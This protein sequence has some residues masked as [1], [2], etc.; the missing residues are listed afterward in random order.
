MDAPRTTPMPTPGR[1]QAAT[2]PAPAHPGAPPEERP[3]PEIDPQ[4]A[5]PEVPMQPPI[6]VPTPQPQPPIV[7]RARR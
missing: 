7:A 5:P 4:P 6:T 2:E 1:L 3:G